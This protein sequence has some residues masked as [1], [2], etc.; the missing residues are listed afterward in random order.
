MGTSPHSSISKHHIRLTSNE[1]KWTGETFIPPSI[2]VTQLGRH[3]SGVPAGLQAAKGGDARY[4]SCAFA[5]LHPGSSATL[6]CG[7]Q[8]SLLFKS[9]STHVYTVTPSDSLDSEVNAEPA[10][11][12]RTDCDTG[13][14]AAGLT[15][16]C[17]DR[18]AGAASTTTVR[19]A[20]GIDVRDGQR[21]ELPNKLFFGQAHKE[22]TKMLMM[23]NGH[24]PVALP[25]GWKCESNSILAWESLRGRRAG[26]SLAGTRIA[27]FDFDNCLCRTSMNQSTSSWS[28]KYS[29]V[30]SKLHDLHQRGYKIVIFTNESLERFKN[31]DPI[32]KTVTKKCARLEA[33]CDGFPDP[34]PIH[35]LVAV[36]GTS[37]QSHPCRKPNRG[38]WDYLIREHVG[39]VIDVDTAAS[40]YVGDAAGRA[41]DFSDSDKQFA[42]N[43]GV[44]FYTD[45]DFFKRN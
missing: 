9:I 17:P 18:S 25:A 5:P 39:N 23:G 45:N 35:V 11:R 32:R 8:L 16:V 6:Q 13:N 3:P 21:G 22:A 44:T 14:E 27:G 42:E 38:M 7:Q 29:N 40:F 24:P 41:T 26:G 43:V 19:S 15:K 37:K 1:A 30:Y 4:T 36:R 2:V 10:K 31:A 34:T 33:F 12:R 20:T 28:L